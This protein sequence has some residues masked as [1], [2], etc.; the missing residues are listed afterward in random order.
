MI[1]K[2]WSP[3]NINRAV[4]R[5]V[6]MFRWA[7]QNELVPPA[8]YHGLK[9]VEGLKAGRSDAKETEPVKPVPQAYVDAVLAKVSAPI[10]ASI[11]ARRSKS[12][13]RSFRFPSEGR[14][15]CR[16]SRAAVSDTSRSL[17]TMTRLW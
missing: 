2:R 11:R 17:P 13:R 3:K 10:G 4:S 6:R 9:S 5:V 1:E 16:V 15:R 14:A 8:L 7:S 12:S